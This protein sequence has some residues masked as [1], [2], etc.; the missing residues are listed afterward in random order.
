MNRI[1]TDGAAAATFLNGAVADGLVQ[2]ILLLGGEPLHHPDIELLIGRL[3][4]PPIVTTNA[5]RLVTDTAF[6][7][8]FARLRLKALNISLPHHSEARRAEVMGVHLFDN[9]ALAAALAE[10]PFPV[11]INCLLLRGW[12]D[13]VAGVEA[14]A[15]F[16]ATLG[17]GELKAAEL[18]ATDTAAHDFV[19]PEVREFNRQHYVR[20]P[21][22]G[23]AAL[24]HREGGTH[25]W[26]LVDGVRVLFNAAPDVA[27]PGGRDR[28]GGLYHRVLFN[29]GMLGNSW[30]RADGMRATPI[31]VKGPTP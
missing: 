23:M 16:G 1:R 2:D 9:G 21:D 10:L 29:D 17:A 12:I 31:T 4:M 7:R 18:T 20:I 3:D 30:R 15:R 5:S 19:A 24:A 13:D 8:R 28:D 27:L 25:F 6:R 26:R 14:M 11:R 22:E